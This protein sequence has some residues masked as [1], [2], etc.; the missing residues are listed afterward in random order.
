MNYLDKNNLE[1][2]TQKKLDKLIDKYKE[3]IEKGYESDRKRL[4][5]FHYNLSNIKIKN[6]DLQHIIVFGCLLNN[7]TFE[8]CDLKDA[9]IRYSEIIN[10]SFIN[11]DFSH[12]YFYKCNFIN[13][14][15]STCNI[16]NSHFDNA[17]FNNTKMPDYPMACPERGSF[18]G[19]KK[20][21]SI[22]DCFNDCPKEYILK[23]EIPKNA[24]HSSAASNKCRC[25]KVKVLEIQNLDGSIA[26][27]ITEVKSFYNDKFIYELGK[28]IEEPKFDE[29]R[30]HEC[31]SGIHF[32]MNR[33]E[34]V[35]Y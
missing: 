29:C 9:D 23:L 11:C 20:V 6:K 32:F 26:E 28:T 18:I 22:D 3:R 2:I 24:K 13:S 17:I 25:D 31:T 16:K 8:N 1:I 5:L 35:N 19:Y 12:G 21:C 33:E 4:N 27:N 14:D 30:W 34:A 10:V 7:V 15:L